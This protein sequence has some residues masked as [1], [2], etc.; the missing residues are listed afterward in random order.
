MKKFIA[1][2]LFLISFGIYLKT[3]CPTVYVG[4]SGELIAAVHTLGIPHNPGY[5]LYCLLGKLFTFLPFGSIAYRINLMSAFFA[6]LTV[7]L[8]YLIILKIQVNRSTGQRVNGST[9]QRGNGATGRPLISHIPAISASL[10]LAFSPTFWSQA[11]IAEVY[12]L[13]AFFLALLIYLL[14]T[15]KEKRDVRLLYLSSLI[16][17]LAFCSHLMQIT[18]FPAMLFLLLTNQSRILLQGKKLAIIFFLFLLGLSLYFYL[19]VRS[20]ANPPIDWGNPENLRNFWYHFSGTEHRHRYLF[21]L[22]FAQT[23]NRAKALSCLFLKQFSLAGLLVGLL[24]IGFLFKRKGEG[25]FLLLIILGNLFYIL[26]LNTVSLKLTAFGIPSYLVIALGIGYGMG[27]LL[28][29]GRGINERYNRIRLGSKSLYEYVA[30]LLI[31][32]LPLLPLSKNYCENDRS[33]YYLAYD[34]G[35]NILKTLEKNAIFFSSGDIATFAIAYLNIVETKRPDVTIYHR[36]GNLYQDIYSFYT[37]RRLSG[38]EREKQR[39]RIEREMVSTT[40]RPVYYIRDVSEELPGYFLEPQGLVYRVRREGVKIR[41]GRNYWKD[42]RMR[43]MED[44]RVFKDYLT[45]RMVAEYYYRLG[46]YYFQRGDRKKAVEQYSK[47]SR[48]GWEVKGRHYSLGQAYQRVGMIDMAILEYEK[49]IEFRP[50]FT[51]AYN[52]LGVCYAQKEQYQEAKREWEK[53]LS[54]NPGHEEAG[55]NLERLKNR[56]Q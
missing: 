7:V 2:L 8:I 12:P 52:N 4:D 27:Y 35:L 33:R 37:G 36:S 29:K 6:S 9:G 21:S 46:N 54:I 51:S 43:G 47:A 41:K 32:V 31:L 55:K 13:N 25:L 56:E 45:R 48:I 10:L 20:L 3:L 1:L 50:H 5:P 38:E 42:Y 16:Y 49:A 24:G 15:W 22:S 23:L 34:Y 44:E 28:E 40:S 17:G 39:N 18:F 26:F 11:V 19:P 53:A 14:L 30:P